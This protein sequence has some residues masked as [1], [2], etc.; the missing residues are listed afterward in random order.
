MIINFF[1][2]LSA[3]TPKVSNNNDL[4]FQIDIYEKGMTFEKF[5]QQLIEY[6]DYAS[7]PSLIQKND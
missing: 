4:G 6:A 1:L 7:Y 3:C 5:K 2:L